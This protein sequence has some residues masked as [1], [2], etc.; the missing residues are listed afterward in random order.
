MN[1][2]ND[3]NTIAASEAVVTLKRD[4]RDLSLVYDSCESRP[5]KWADNVLKQEGPPLTRSAL[6]SLELLAKLFGKKLVDE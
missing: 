4:L 6:Q 5:D 3:V 1:V 2:L